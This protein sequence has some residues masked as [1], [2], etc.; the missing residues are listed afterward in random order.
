MKVYIP[1]IVRIVPD[2]IVK[3]LVAFLEACYIS[4]CQD[5]DTD[6][7]DSLEHQLEIFKKL[8]EIFCTSGTRHKGFFLPRQHSMFHYHCLIE[9]FGAPSRLCSSITESCHIT[10]IKKLWHH[11]NRYEALGQMLVI[12]QQ[13]NKL[14]AMCSNFAACGML[15]VLPFDMPN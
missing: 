10:A 8:Q 9:D 7:L 14:A 2:D 15:S 5:I 6:A 4:Q 11:S 1:A 12:N 13:L 3:C